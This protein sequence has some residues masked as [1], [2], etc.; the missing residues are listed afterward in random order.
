L[1]EHQQLDETPMPTAKRQV[2]DILKRLPETATWDDIMYGIS[3]RK[4]I[5]AGAKAA[6]EGK[7]VPH[8][9]VIAF[10]LLTGAIRRRMKERGFSE[11]VILADF[12][13]AR[14]SRP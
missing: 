14:K 9:R 12:E 10:Y 4:K 1:T 11:Q 7:V 5:A 2:L 8:E 13:K 6:N 3:V